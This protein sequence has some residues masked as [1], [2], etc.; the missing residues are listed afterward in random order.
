MLKAGLR[1]PLNILHRELLKCLGLSVNQVSPNAW[2]IFIARE[3][4]YGAM[5]NGAR[6]LTV[7]EFLHYYRP[8]E[9][10]KSRGVYSFVPRSPLLKVIYKTLDSNRDW[11]SRYFFL[12]GD[13]WMGSLR[14]T[15]HMPVDTTWGILHPSRMHPS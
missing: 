4:L 1:F 2:R 3:I 13:G 15:D 14:D 12:E 8:D 6:S 5:S 9:I 11:K 7:R 10:D